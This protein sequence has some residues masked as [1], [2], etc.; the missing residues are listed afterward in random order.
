MERELKSE[1]EPPDGLNN[2]LKNLNKPK[3]PE[4]YW[5]F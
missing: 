1:A 2:Q 4:L 5:V 3:Q